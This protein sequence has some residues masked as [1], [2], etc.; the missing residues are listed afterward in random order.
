MTTASRASLRFLAWIGAFWSLAG[1]ASAHPLDELAQASYV[2]VGRARVAVEL[3]LTP[4]ERVAG[5]YFASLDENKDGTLSPAERGVCE[6]R[7]LGDLRLSLDGKPLAPTLARSEFPTDAILKSGGGSVKLF[8]TTDFAPLAPG[9]HVLRYENRHEPLKSGYLVAV[10]V[11]K[12]GAAV[13][14][15]SRDD[16]QQA[17]TLEFSTPA[18]PSSPLLPGLGA[19]LIA[20]G[21]AVFAFRRWRQRRR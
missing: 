14:T 15:Q 8:A 12:D 17:L 5:K 1:A 11:G 13:G 16:R 4:G 18:A 19:G 3:N 2:E 21:A 10:L 7:V 6:K 20:L 9:K